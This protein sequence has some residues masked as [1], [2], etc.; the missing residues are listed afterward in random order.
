MLGLIRSV[1]SSTR[2]DI[3][4][5]GD[6][7]IFRREDRMAKPT[8][9]CMPGARSVRTG[10]ALLLLSLLI[11]G[12]LCAMSPHPPLFEIDTERTGQ[13][14][15]WVVEEKVLVDNPRPSSPLLITMRNGEHAE[16]HAGQNHGDGYELRVAGRLQGWGI[17]IP[18]EIRYELED[19]GQTI[20]VILLAQSQAEESK[21]ISTLGWSLPLALEP[22]KRVWFQGDYDLEWD[23]RYFY[24]Y[25]LGPSGGLLP[26]PDRNEWRFFGLDCFAGEGFRL[27]KSESETTAPIIMQEGPQA[28]PAFQIYDAN[29]GLS[30]EV[31]G[32]DNTNFMS[33][34]VDAA[35]SGEI[36]ARF[37]IGGGGQLKPHD[38]ARAEA[39]TSVQLEIVLTANN[40]E[41]A[42]RADRERLRKGHVSSPRPEPEDVM[43]EPEWIRSAP[44]PAMQYVTGGY[45][46]FYGELK[47]AG[48]VQVEVT[49]SPVPVQCSP[50]GYWPD[51]S[52]K[53]ALLTFAVD[54]ASAVEECA[55]PRVSLRSGKFLPVS[56]SIG[57]T[58]SQP[59]GSSLAVTQPNDTSVVVRDGPLEVE[60]AADTQWLKRMD[61]N[62]TPMLSSQGSQPV[63]YT[64]YV[65]DPENVLP[66][67]RTAQG[68]RLDEG[69]LKVES[70]KV[71]ESGP[72]RAVVRLEGLTD[73]EEPTRIILRVEFL[74]G[75]NTIRITHTAVFR[76]QDPRR[77]F[78]TAMGIRIPLANRLLGETDFSGIARVQREG[79]QSASLLQETITSSVLLTQSDEHLKAVERAGR[80]QGWMR[81][82]GEEI[83]LT[84]VIRNFWQM[85][86]KGLASAFT[87][88]SLDFELWPSAAPP[89]DVRR[90]SNYP[91]RAQ[92]ES[93]ESDDEWVHSSYYTKEPFAGIARTHEM[94]LAVDELGEA[95]DPEGIAADFQSPPLLYAGWDSYAWTEV[96]LPAPDQNQ[97]PRSW[98]AWTRLANFWLWHQT[99]YHWQGF[100]NFGDLRHSFQRGYGWI[101][102]V[103]TLQRALAADNPAKVEIARHERI[104]DYSPSNDWAYDNGRWGW[105]NTEGLPN[106]FLQNE[107]LRHGNR[108]VYFAAEALARHSRDVIAR[109]EGYWFGRGTR[110]G[111][112]H[113]SDGNHEERQTTPTEYRLHYFLSGDRRTRD[114]TEKL[115]REVYSRKPVSRHAWHSGR[116]G[117]LL[118]HW[119]LTGSTQEADQFKRYVDLFISDDG[120]YTEPDVRFP[121]AFAA[122]S[123][124]SLNDGLMFFHT[125]GGMHAM[126]EYFQIT[127]DPAICDAII[128]MADAMMQDKTILGR[129]RGGSFSNHSVFWPAVAFAAAHAPDPVPY[130]N[131][132]RQFLE[133][134]AWASQYQTVTQN[135]EH[136]SGPSGYLHRNVATSFFWNNW[137]PF[138]A[139]AMGPREVWNKEI[140][141]SYADNEKRGTIRPS[142]RTSWQSEFDDVPGTEEYLET[143]QP[144]R[145]KNSQR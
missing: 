93:V 86:P 126:V 44:E 75:S 84:A 64:D 42:V 143:Q 70:I 131:F 114:L 129:A 121:G 38:G 120:L 40:S 142:I 110:H 19:D 111:V 69:A 107:Y 92:G 81:S 5:Q 27:W 132:M 51:G 125:F 105:S 85:A 80:A 96:A 89:M 56:V 72:L 24:Q 76:F 52:I 130:Q 109:Q 22:R 139:A 98:D 123:H 45:P 39:G 43:R 116:L 31:P 17:E 63:A 119:E 87:N 59:T 28:I 49:G 135:L 21:Q 60:L 97:W 61:W 58:L 13:I 71:E 14:V 82:Q 112:Q 62:G 65:I 68:G 46:F 113:W 2:R 133:A 4:V 118:F 95:R 57:E 134:G 37:H 15:R 50:L 83:A 25:L 8:R 117:G 6:Q 41:N 33:L 7:V 30:V 26:R 23:E 10:V 128:G 101:T 47:S 138:I 73:N 35:G 16:F 115:Y 90:Y 32:A 53:W 94:L 106:L 108:A 9:R 77:T 99:L 54:T 66:F 137:A 74:A 12:E 78:L 122:G 20:R 144:W 141:R 48:D 145:I 91:H 79:T 1:V 102:H 18:A 88:D 67:E 104:L 29:G 103:D 124:Q 136:W 36:Q 34:R 127:K 3:S 11:P 100:W 140:E 55:P